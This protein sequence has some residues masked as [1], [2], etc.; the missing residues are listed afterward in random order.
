MKNK[1]IFYI[2]LCVFTM[3]LVSIAISLFISPSLDDVFERVKYER[4]IE[5]NMNFWVENEGQITDV[6]TIYFYG[7]VRGEED[8]F[9][10]MLIN[11]EDLSREMYMLGGSAYLYDGEKFLGAITANSE[12]FD[13]NASDEEFTNFVLFEDFAYWTTNQKISNGSTT[14]DIDFDKRLIPRL[15]GENIGNYF[16][17]KFQLTV[18]NSTRLPELMRIELSAY[19][20]P[21]L[22]CESKYKY[23]RLYKEKLPEELK[24]ITGENAGLK[25]ELSADKRGYKVTEFQ[26]INS[27]VIIPSEYKGLP[28]TAIGERAFYGCDIETVT[29]PE[30]VTDLGSYSFAGCHKLKKVIIL[31]NSLTYLPEYAFAYCSELNEVNSDD[32]VVNMP[33][34]I[35]TL[36]EGVFRECINITEINFSPNITVL[37]DYCCGSCYKLRSIDLPDG[38]TSINSFA[39]INCELRSVT[40]P[41]SVTVI[42]PY[43]FYSCTRLNTVNILG[44]GLLSIEERAFAYCRMLVSFNFP[45]S[46][47]TIGDYAFLCADMTS[48][49]IPAQVNDIGIGAFH[50]KCLTEI[51]VAANSD[52]YK[53]VNG[54]LYNQAGTILI[55][56]PSGNTDETFYVPDDV[57]IIGEH[58]FPENN[59]L[60]NLVLPAGIETIGNTA[61]PYTLQKL[62]MLAETPPEF[63]DT[64]VYVLLYVPFESIDAYKTEYYWL[65]DVIYAITEN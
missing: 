14:Y 44:S 45:T 41:S 29:I 23:H 12:A 13:K 27:T 2:S 4:Y 61:F 9:I 50:C 10:H 53:S 32:G 26:G 8:C 18:K 58:A 34:N 48:V 6:A 52:Y 42:Q 22:V 24:G 17:C 15:F 55:Y 33:I 63:S 35:A 25:Y 54:V 39:F 49:C 46:L 37:P 59:N 38:L 16:N 36:G 3:I 30:S 65:R 60:K 62:T 1:M 64:Q 31:G 40:I 20:T 28:V 21:T 47:N 19:E 57:S 5:I 11:R 56:Y 51:E 43:A 7:E